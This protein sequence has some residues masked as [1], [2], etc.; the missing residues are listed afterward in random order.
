M[1]ELVL[2]KKK[3]KS[4]MSDIKENV[5][6]RYWK[7]KKQMVQLIITKEFLKIKLTAIRNR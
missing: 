2:K 5:T 7:W 1:S 4:S 3:I 6:F